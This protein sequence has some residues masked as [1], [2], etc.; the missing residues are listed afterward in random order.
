MGQVHGD[1]KQGIRRAG[2]IREHVAAREGHCGAKAFERTR[3]HL[4]GVLPVGGPGEAELRGG[5]RDA[6]EPLRGVVVLCEVREAGCAVGGGRG[7]GGAVE[8]SREVLRCGAAEGCAWVDADG[9]EPHGFGQV[10]GR[11]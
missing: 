5:S 10:V 3:R 9:Q 8:G 11:C 7:E 6:G 1:R 2:G 4:L